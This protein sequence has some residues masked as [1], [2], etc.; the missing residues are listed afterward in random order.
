MNR[1][2][3]REFDDRDSEDYARTLLLT[4]PC[5]GMDEAWEN[6]KIAKDRSK[7]EKGELWVAKTNG[8]AIGFMLLEFETETRNVEID[9]LDV[10]PEYQR[11][12]VDHELVVRAGERAR[13]AKC[14]TLTIHTAVSNTKMRQFARKTG[15]V[16]SEILPSFWGENTEDAY[17][18]LKTLD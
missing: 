4:L 13:A 12:G 15:F 11:H 7:Q 14:M 3:I 16:E 9:W 5:D 1:L 18:L 8:V 10:H 17:L 6:V 2:Q